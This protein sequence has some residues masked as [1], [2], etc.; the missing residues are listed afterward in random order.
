[1]NRP[2]DWTVIWNGSEFEPLPLIK[3]AIR[4]RPMKEKHA[5]NLATKLNA[6]IVTA[7][8]A[9]AFGGEEIK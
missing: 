1:M 6:D 8:V 5:I 9:R 7:D 3:A 4:L 2:N